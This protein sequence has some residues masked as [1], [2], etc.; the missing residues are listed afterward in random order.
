MVNEIIV[1]FLG[2]LH[3]DRRPESKPFTPFGARDGR[4][5]RVTPR[6][7]EFIRRPRPRPRGQ[8]LARPS[9]RS[10][11]AGRRLRAVARRSS[12]WPGR[13]CRAGMATVASRNSSD[14]GDARRPRASAAAPG[15]GP[16]ARPH[17]RRAPEASPGSGRHR[18]RCAAVPAADAAVAGRP[19]VGR[20]A[21]APVAAAAAAPVT[22]GRDDRG[23]RA[24]RCAGAWP[25]GGRR[26]SGSAS[27]RCRPPPLVGA[28]GGGAR[29]RVARAGWF[30]AV[31]PGTLRGRADDRQDVRS[32]D[33]VDPAR[34]AARAPAAGS[35]GPPASG[36]VGRASAGRRTGELAVTRRR[37][38]AGRPAQVRPSEPDPPDAADRAAAPVLGSLGGSLLPCRCRTGCAE[39]RARP[40]AQSP[41]TRPRRRR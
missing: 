28:T 32:V 6:G 15:R 38:G 25:A 19:A 40:A 2:T 11:Q 35:S 39:A 5:H 23:R 31:R 20:L 21:G 4:P 16:A 34:A 26:P 14:P 7:A 30:G 37:L 33:L 10:A 27:A 24:A 17:V 22:R 36:S 13:R 29:R 8:L 9:S 18:R 3:L 12:L 41:H 1:A